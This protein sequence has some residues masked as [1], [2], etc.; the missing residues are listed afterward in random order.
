[1]YTIMYDRG[2][3]AKWLSTGII[4]SAVEV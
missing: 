1:M 4:S 3:K 2:N